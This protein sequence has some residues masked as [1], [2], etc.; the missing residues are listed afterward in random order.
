VAEQY[1]AVAGK[2]LS[3]GLLK[4]QEATLESSVTGKALDGLFL[5]IGEEEKK[6]RQDTIG[7]GRDLLGKVFGAVR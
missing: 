4:P 1:N 6:I 3:L 5:I 7:S 2:A